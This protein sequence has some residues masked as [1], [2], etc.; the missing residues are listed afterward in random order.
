[1][2]KKVFATILA[3]VF[4][5]S[6]GWVPAKADG[7]PIDPLTPAPTAETGEMT[8]ETPNLW[9]V[10]LTSAPSIEGTSS[11]TLQA[12]H[13][14]FRSE[15]KNDGVKYRE[16]VSYDT[17]WNGFTVFAEPSELGK[18]SSLS[19]VQG[20]YPVST[21]KLPESALADPELFT[22]LAMIG[23]DVAQSE[24]GYTGAG[25][26]VAV[27]DTGIDY[28]HP[29]FGGDGVARSNSTVFPTAR[30]IKGWDF[31]GDA[32]NADDTSPSYN[33]N[34]SPDPYP[35]DCNGHGTHVA[36]IVGANDPANGLKGVAPE[37]KFGSYRV[38]GCEGSTTDEIMLMAMERAY[39]DHMQ[40]LNM[41]IGS[42]FSWPQAPT[43]VAASRLVKKGVVVVASI[44]NE[45][46]YG[47]YSAGAPGVGDDVIGVASYDN[48]NVY[49]PYFTVNGRNIGYMT[50]TYSDPAPLSGDVEV[51]YVG[52]GCLNPV[53]TS[54]PPVPTGG[55]PYLADPAG[56]TAL[57]ERG[58]C[59]FAEKALRAINAGATAVVIYN[60]TSGVVAGTLGGSIGSPVP[61]VG[62]SKADGLFLRAQTAPIMMTWTDQQASFPSPTG[63]LISS[64]SS[65]GLAADLSLKPDIGAPGGNIYSTFPLE[66]GGYASLSGTSMSSPHVAGAAALFL[67]AH[68]KTKAEDVRTYLQNSAVPADWWGYPGLGYLD[69]VSRQGAGMLQIDKAILATAK[70]EPSKLSLGESEKGPVTR[71]LAITNS[72]KAS[73]TYTLSYVNALSVVNTFAPDFWDSDANV[74]FNAASITV[75][76]GKSA[77]VKATITPPTYPD[78]GLYGGYIVLS[79]SD[80]SILRVPFAGFVGNYQSIQ[81]IAPT[82]YEFPWLAISY[83]GSF[84]GPITGPSDWTYSM[85]GEDVPYILIHFD[86]QMT[87]LLVEVHDAA[88]GKLVNRDYKYA[89]VEKYLPRNSTSTGFFA[90]AWDGSLIREDK[91]YE[92]RNGKPVHT[93]VAPDG[94]YVLVVKGLKALGNERN[95]AD[96]ETW[97]SPA[98]IID[99]P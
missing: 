55:D 61:V 32:Y 78:Q 38:F 69:N 24:L 57:I 63:G 25:I 75:R 90:L 84:Y 74:S 60:N 67:Q 33:P 9:F 28:D 35:D 21:I 45:G 88:T 56:K 94:E 49:L 42:A 53:S 82:P 13:N 46:S 36:G 44:G 87:K 50:M 39:K 51:V 23:A 47:L 66:Q 65:Y 29:A 64:F 98:F 40:V 89:L 19:G 20:I 30:V 95:P 8:D 17:L 12:E 52:R 97:E 73:V 86:H 91:G 59:S 43:A 96:W 3:V 7:G 4:I 34:P 68:P 85:Q 22:S 62:I 58:V 93:K 5:A 31:V 15:A 6:A 41:S 27:M 37:V 48:T 72:G 92:K 80:G 18:I 79:G 77:A 83:E 71:T 14:T 1:M 10:E 11:T 81:A 26:K 76:G 99:R 54:T 70:V 2:F 16:R